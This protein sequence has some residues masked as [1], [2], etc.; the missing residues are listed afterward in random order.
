[1]T[2]QL[3]A[4]L[5]AA[6]AGIHPDEAAAGLMIGHGSFLSRSDFAVH[7]ETAVGIS[8]GAPMAWIDG[9]LSSPPSTT[10]ASRPADPLGLGDIVGV[11]VQRVDGELVASEASAEPAGEELARV[12][13]P[14][15]AVAEAM[16]IMSGSDDPWIYLYNERL[17][18]LPGSLAAPRGLPT[19]EVLGASL[20]LTD[21]RRR[22]VD[23]PPEYAD[24]GRLMG[25]YGP[26]LRRWH[27]TTDQLAHVREALAA[28]PW[29]RRAVIQLYDPEA[30]ARGHKDVPCTLGYRFFLRDGMLHMHTTMRS[31]DLWL[32]FCYDIF[33]ATIL[34][35]DRVTGLSE[36]LARRPSS[37]SELHGAASAMARSAGCSLAASHSHCL[38][39]PSSRSTWGW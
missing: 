22:L 20:T 4:A 16:W 36:Q 30:D 25:A 8:D 3:S 23:V 9:T 14:A 1:M 17:A 31:Q 27:G 21:P 24:D 11:Q 34:Q 7:I 33:T 13:N 39:S 12:I 29:T 2:S 32:G 38:R 10:A 35:E 18:L 5:R 26:R 15:F 6:A 28:D 37:E 19:V